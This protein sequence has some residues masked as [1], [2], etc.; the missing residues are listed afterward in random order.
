MPDQD[1]LTTGEVATALN[2]TEQTIRN[3]IEQG[4]I[5]AVRDG[6]RFLIARE[7]FDRFL[8]AEAAWADRKPTDG[9]EGPLAA[10]SRPWQR[11]RELHGHAGNPEVAETKFNE[12]RQSWQTALGAHAMAPPDDGFAGR[13]R[14]LARAAA[15]RGRACA[16]AHEAG[17]EWPTA[18][19]GSQ[20]P[21]ELRPGTGRRGPVA[22]WHR[23]DEAAEELDR[24][25]SSRSMRAVGRAYEDLAEITAQISAAV[26][27]ED[28]GL[29]DAA[30]AGAARR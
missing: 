21:Y 26:E 15:D 23:F 28:R 24:V 8:G 3:W 22:L 27:S 7:E 19:S 20:P 17:F 1:R 2:V 30:R 11:R 13:L 10:R 9:A 16:E 14:D 6:R 4:R 18:Q 25:T 12:A 29:R 5:E